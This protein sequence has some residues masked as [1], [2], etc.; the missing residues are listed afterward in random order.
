[1]KEKTEYKL[2]ERTV[3]ITSEEQRSDEGLPFCENRR[4]VTKMYL[5]RLMN[6]DICSDNT[7]MRSERAVDSC[8]N[9]MNMR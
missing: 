5:E 9:R 7:T 6:R 3:A 1:M 8:C 4:V 2:F